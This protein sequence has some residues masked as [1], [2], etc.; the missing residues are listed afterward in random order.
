MLCFCLIL[1]SVVI[2]PSMRRLEGQLA[3][4]FHIQN[5]AFIFR[6]LV[7]SRSK[8]SSTSLALH[9]SLRQQSLRHGQWSDCMP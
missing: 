6:L 1:E 8:S 5:F 2:L 3:C 7:I 4:F 9:K